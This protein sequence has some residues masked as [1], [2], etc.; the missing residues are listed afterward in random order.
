MVLLSQINEQHTHIMMAK[1]SI[2]LFNKGRKIK[3]HEKI[4]C[5]FTF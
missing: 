3:H 2:L 1:V 4:T 5:K